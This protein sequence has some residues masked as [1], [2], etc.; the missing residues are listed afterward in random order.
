MKCA[1]SKNYNIISGRKVTHYG[2]GQCTPCRINQRRKRTARVLLEATGTNGP[3]A[4]VT[5]TYNDENCPH[6]L[7]ITHLRRFIESYR[8]YRKRNNLRGMVRYFAAGEYGTKTGRPHFHVML[9]GHETRYIFRDGRQYDPVIES[10]WP[11]GGTHTENANHNGSLALRCAYL[12][13]YITKKLRSDKADGRRPEFSCGSQRP[14]G[15]GWPGLVKIAQSYLLPDGSAFSAAGQA[16]MELHGGAVPYTFRY[17]GRTYPLDRWCREKLADL[18]SIPL[19]SNKMQN[20]GM[21]L[22]WDS[23]NN[24]FAGRVM[25]YEER[26]QAEAADPPETI[27]EAFAR[28]DKLDRKLPRS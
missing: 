21:I 5:L 2:C 18:W 19:K 16:F 17:E 28:W 1:S 22:E 27:H 12:A 7:D 10:S 23:T 20:P 26:L 13:G 11:H 15:I 25:S 6:E 4:F 14:A 24:R 9:F 3:V 8:R